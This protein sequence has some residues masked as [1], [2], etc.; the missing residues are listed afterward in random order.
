V[1]CALFVENEIS[2][3]KNLIGE[4]K[5]NKKKGENSAFF[6]TNEI[7]LLS[8]YMNNTLSLFFLK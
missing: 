2:F 5:K 4:Q 7:S 8:F 3:E 1:L 6:F